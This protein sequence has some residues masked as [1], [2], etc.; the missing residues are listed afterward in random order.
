MRRAE[1]T[2]VDLDPAWSSLTGI[3][4]GHLSSVAVKAAAALVGDRSIRTS[5]TTF[6]RPAAA[7][8]AT[9]CAEEQRRGR[10]LSHVS[11]TIGQSGEPVAVS[12]ITASTDVDGISWDNSAALELPP[13]D[14]CIPIAPPLDIRHFDHCE[15]MLDPEDVPFSHGRRA[16]VAGYLRPRQPRPIDAEWLAMALDWF[17]P[18]S[19]TR[20]DPPTGGISINYTIHLHRT[21]ATLGPGEWLRGSFHVEVSAGGIA[22]EK[23]V[24]ADPTGE[25]LAESFHTRW[26]AAPR[27]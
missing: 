15:A 25:I 12:Q 14:R 26:T 22:L 13:T 16:R 27:S 8:P 11:V 21:A 2:E 6:L 1:R 5:T 18:A 19:F 10:S 4:G 17:P 3:H 20:V 23:G 24:I 9:L 7:G